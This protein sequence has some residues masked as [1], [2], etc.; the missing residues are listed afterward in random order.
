[1]EDARVV[2]LRGGAFQIRSA[3]YTGATPTT[4]GGTPGVYFVLVATT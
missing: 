4:I 1:L 3:S 2:D